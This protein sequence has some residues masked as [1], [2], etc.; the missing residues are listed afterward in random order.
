MIVKV[1]EREENCEKPTVALATE[2]ESSLSSAIASQ[3]AARAALN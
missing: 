2:T 3:R 1:K